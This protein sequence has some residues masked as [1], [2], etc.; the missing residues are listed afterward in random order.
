MDQ[1]SAMRILVRVIE[2]GSFT[3]VAREMGTSQPTISKQIRGLEKRL[4]TSLL[5][6]ST[7]HVAPT[8]QGLLY[9]QECRAILQTL[10]EV[11]LRIANAEGQLSGVLRVG[12]PSAFGRMEV[13]PHLAPFLEM[14]SGLK[15]EILLSDDIANLLQSGI[16][17]AFRCGHSLPE[18]VVAR[19][20]GEIPSNLFASKEYLARYGIPQTPEQLATHHCI[21]YQNTTVLQ[22][23]W[24]LK[25]HDEVF[26]VPV[27]GQLSC[28]S[29]DGL[30]AAVLAH[31]GISYAQSWLFKTELAEGEVIALLPA[32]HLSPK[33]L[34]AIYLPERRGNLRI[35]ALIA[36]ME[37]CWRHHGTL[38]L[39]D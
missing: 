35:G 29:S 27:N 7:R 13:I 11:E 24:Q 38:S 22:R 18:G 12:V 36:Y 15:I 34:Y 10:D 23:Y 25:L 5:A 3:A 39:I 19:K 8:A 37:Q 31:L 14:H 16:D 26:T 2:S 4:G 1:L 32:Y 17:V 30:R 33:P 21:T 9:Y 20:L 28:N 6:R